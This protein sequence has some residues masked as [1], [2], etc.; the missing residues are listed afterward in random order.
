M[1]EQFPEGIVL[2]SLWPRSVLT[3]LHSACH[4]IG[5][6]RSYLAKYR[7]LTNLSIRT[8]FTFF[9]RSFVIFYLSPS[10]GILSFPPTLLAQFRTPILHI[11]LV[12]WRWQYFSLVRRWQQLSRLPDWQ[13]YWGLQQR[14]YIRDFYLGRIIQIAILAV[15]FREP[16][17]TLQCIPALIIMFRTPTFAVM[18]RTP[19]RAFLCRSPTLTYCSR[20][21]HWPIV[22]VS[23]IGNNSHVSITESSCRHVGTYAGSYR[24]TL[25]APLWGPQNWH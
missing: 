18:F 11:L 15:L 22:H 20:L 3:R 7:I 1:V 8:T 6:Y 13:Q 4:V 10:L 23:D 25:Y 21:R 2:L 12:F 5:K 9:Y 16:A 19:T 24:R 17:L 14:Q